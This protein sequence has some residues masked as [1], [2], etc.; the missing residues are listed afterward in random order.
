MTNVAN[1]E[2]IVLN[3]CSIKKKKLENVNSVTYNI[4]C[5]INVDMRMK[6]FVNSQL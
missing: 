3:E 5:D 2:I 1:S 4:T 6:Y